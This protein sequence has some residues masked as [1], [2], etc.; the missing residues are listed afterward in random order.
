M[1]SLQPR[2]RL[3]SFPVRTAATGNARSPTVDSRVDGTSNADVNDDRRRYRPGILAEWRRP[4]R[5]VQS[6]DTL[7]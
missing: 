7:V 3:Q 5:P 1:T 2:L 6:T 4:D